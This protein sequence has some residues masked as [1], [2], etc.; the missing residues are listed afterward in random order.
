MTLRV[1][2]ITMFIATLLCW[3]SFGLVL[4]NVDPEVANV[5]TFGFFYASLFLSLTGT[6]SLLLFGWY[7][8]WWSDEVPLFAYV[9]KSF[10]EGNVVAAFLT[11]TLFLWGVDWLSWWTGSLMAT[12][13]ILTISLMWSMAPRHEV[14]GNH[15]RTNN[16]I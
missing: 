11:V 9:S 14:S 8:K 3:L 13:F 15:H 10:R 1:Y 6:I 2:L 7:R 16:F 4:V 5:L 12:A